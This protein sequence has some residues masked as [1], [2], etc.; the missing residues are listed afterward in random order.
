MSNFLNAMLVAVAVGA[1]VFAVGAQTRPSSKAA[2]SVKIGFI[3][4]GSAISADQFYFGM[5][6]AGN[7]INA[8]AT[9]LQDVTLTFPRIRMQSATTRPAAVYDSVA[10]LCD[11]G[12]Y[13]AFLCRTNSATAQAIALICPTIPTYPLFYRSQMPITPNI[14]TMIAMFRYFGWMKTGIVFSAS[15]V[16]PEA[17]TVS[18][19]LFPAYGIQVLTSIKIPDYDATISTLHSLSETG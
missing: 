8:N 16:Y 13:R 12:Q 4:V 6:M 9:I 14:L 1:L 7:E 2:N 15:G 11:S 10:S 19:Q 17:N 18:K 3:D 5:L